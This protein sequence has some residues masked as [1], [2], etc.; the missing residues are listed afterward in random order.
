MVAQKLKAKFMTAPFRHGIDGV[1]DDKD[2]RRMYY[3]LSKYTMANFVKVTRV[4]QPVVVERLV[5][6]NWKM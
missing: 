2:V 5:K 6:H 1:L 4:L 3:A